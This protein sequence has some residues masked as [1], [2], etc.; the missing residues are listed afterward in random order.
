MHRA[1]QLFVRFVELLVL[2]SAAPSVKAGRVRSR[3]WERDSQDAGGVDR[4]QRRG[5]PTAGAGGSRAA[6]QPHRAAVSR[7]SGGDVQKTDHTTEQ[8]R[9]SGTPSSLSPALGLSAD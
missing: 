6:D 2:A 3:G 8:T 9:D 5:E 7:R 4:A 1:G